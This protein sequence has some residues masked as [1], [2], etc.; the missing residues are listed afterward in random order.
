MV[1]WKVTWVVA[2]MTGFVGV[3]LT[4]FG[5]SQSARPRQF[6][7]TNTYIIEDLS[8]TWKGATWELVGSVE[9]HAMIRRPVSGRLQRSIRSFSPSNPPSERDLARP[10]GTSA[11]YNL[12]AARTDAAT[13]R[14]NTAKSF[15][16]T[17][18]ATC[19]MLLR[20]GH[21]MTSAMRPCSK[22]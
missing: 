11:A 21:R 3:L 4:A 10:F 18:R 5:T 9:S 1:G 2:A 20:P 15:E 17:H 8:I 16:S 22:R 13:G 19:L 12:T 6:Y 14:E 7:R